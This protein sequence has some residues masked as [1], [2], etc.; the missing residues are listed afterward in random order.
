MMGT[1]LSVSVCNFFFFF[2]WQCV[3]I[4]FSLYL[5]IWIKDKFNA[6]VSAIRLMSSETCETITQKIL[7]NR[8][9]SS[10]SSSASPSTLLS[11]LS[12]EDDTLP[13]VDT[14][15]TDSKKITSRYHVC[16]KTRHAFS[17]SELPT[18]V[19]DESSVP[20]GISKPTFFSQFNLIIENTTTPNHA[21]T[22]LLDLHKS[23]LQ[24]ESSSAD[25][26]IKGILYLDFL[27]FPLYNI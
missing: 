17:P 23:A 27:K 5:Q 14:E 4:Y 2:F 10:S 7:S 25:P 1:E 18:P 20:L 6:Q 22:P 11:V 13:G 8:G 26:S 16:M 24:N 21:P 3:T 12:R 19:R 15:Y 9:N